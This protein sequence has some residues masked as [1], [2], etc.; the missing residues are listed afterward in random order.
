MP[1]TDI[2]NRVMKMKEAMRTLGLSRNTIY[3]LINEGKLRCARVGK[4]GERLF[5][6]SEINNYIE[7]LF[8][9]SK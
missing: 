5:T 4:R 3:K 1:T 8:S 6:A 7:N 9:V 2:D